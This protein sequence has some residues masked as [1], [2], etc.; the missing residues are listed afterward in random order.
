MTLKQNVGQVLV[1]QIGQAATKVRGAQGSTPADL[2]RLAE[3]ARSR[4]DWSLDCY[5]RRQICAQPTPRA[6]DWIQYGHSL[7]EAGF[8]GRAETAYLTAL[9][10][11]PDDPEIPLQ[12]GHLAKVRGRFQAAAEAFSKALDAGYPSEPIAFERELARKMDNGTVFRDFPPGTPREGVRLFLS[13]P[14]AAVHETDKAGLAASLGAADYSYSF[15]MRGFIDALEALEM[16]YTLLANPEFVSD[17]AERSSGA[18]NIHL[19]FYP[20]ERMRVLKG[21]YNVNCFAW[22]FDRLRSSGE[23]LSYHAFADQATMLAIADEIWIPSEHGAQAVR[24]STQ[25]PVIRIPAPIVS[26]LKKKPREA[27]PARR[28]VERLARGLSDI[29][30]EPLTILPRLQPQLDESAR[31]RQ[32]TIQSIMSRQPADAAPVFYLSVFNVHDFRKQIEPMLRGFVQFSEDHPEA[33]LL[34]KATTPHR[35]KKIINRILMEEQVADTGRLIAPLI[36]D[37]IFITD[38]VLSRDELNRLYDLATFYVCTSYAEGQNLPLLEAMGRGVVPVSVDHTAMADYVDETD[39]VVIPS[40]R[41][42]L[43]PRLA[44][45]YGLYGVMTNYV[46]A[47]AVAEALARASDL[48]NDAYGRM[49]AAAHRQVTSQFTAEAFQDQLQGL[50][51]RLEDQPEEA[52]P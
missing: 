11:K 19:G 14:A 45:R 40:A 25:V 12:L 36:S 1:K 7:K 33:I 23:T 35:A 18:I 26:N 4:R 8:H 46:E 5:Y 42:E 29:F 44:A 10:M 48:P 6:G 41:R 2:R 9:A 3:Q 27:P 51:R 20:P 52:H 37:R 22:E 15:A 30:W 34:L 38:A 31:G 39:A 43:D 24:D 13:A 28:E 47:G 32:A 50:I 17:I 49:S 16:D 21:A